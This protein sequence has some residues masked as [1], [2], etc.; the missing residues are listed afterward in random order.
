MDSDKEIR[1]Y[2]NSINAIYPN[3][4]NEKFYKF[5]NSSNPKKQIFLKNRRQFITS[6][7]ECNDVIAFDS[8]TLFGNCKLL[9]SSDS[10]ISRHILNPNFNDCLKFLFY[11]A[12][13]K[14]IYRFFYNIDF[15][16]SAILKLYSKES[17]ENIEFID[18]ISKGIEVQYGKYKMKWIRSKMFILKHITRKRS[19]IF[20]DLFNF[21]KMGLDKTTKKY[22]K[23]GKSKEINPKSLNVSKDYWEYNIEKIIDYCKR[24]CQITRELGLILISTIKKSKINL[25]KFLTTPASLSKQFFRNNCYIPSVFNIPS[26]ILEIAYKCYFGGRF[27]MFIK[28]F[29]KEMYLYDIVSQYPSFIKDLPDLK[30]G[31]WKKCDKK[32]FNSKSFFWKNKQKLGYFLVKV[33]IPSNYRIPTIPINL[34]G[35]VNI[36]PNGI[37]T[38]WATWYDLQLIHKFIEKYYYG[39]YF[40]KSVNNKKIFE[41]SIDFLFEKKENI[42]KKKEPLLYNILKLTMNALYGCFIERNEN[43]NEKLDCFEIQC[44]VLF[45]SIYASQITSFGRWSVLKDIKRS[46]Y[47]YIIA[48][49]TDSIITNK[50]LKYLDIGKELGQWNLEKKGKGIIINTGMYQIDKLIKTRGIPKVYIKDWFRFSNKNKDKESIMFYIKHMKKIRECIVQDKSLTFLNTMQKRK[51]S[52][53]VNSDIKRTWERKIDNFYDISHYSIISLPLER[54]QKNIYPNYYSLIE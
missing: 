24:D 11:K 49:H 54:I 53:S 16:I 2:Y 33:N 27:E 43:Y 3:L 41:K 45:N 25:P 44:G 10:K 48:I 7:Y 42:N 51:R 34:N 35:M 30:N 40:V 46:D 26:R 22:I 52:V 38:T 29:Q 9:C 37:Y 19:V 36:F 20:T 50:E 18:K 1:E 17:N 31:Y 21:F 39:Y 32:E 12:D 4:I 8:E 28:G 5:H 6:K 14:G 13:S 47:K 15:D 23:I